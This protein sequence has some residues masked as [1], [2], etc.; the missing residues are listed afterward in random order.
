MWSVGYQNRVKMVCVGFT[1]EGIFGK[2]SRLKIKKKIV[3][4]GQ[5]LMPFSSLADRFFFSKKNK[6]RLC[7]YR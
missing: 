6:D 2:Y 7:V 3:E 1:S 4:E 5:I